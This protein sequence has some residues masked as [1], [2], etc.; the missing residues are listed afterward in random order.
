MR[1]IATLFL[2]LILA[3]GITA[4]IKLLPKKENLKDFTAKTTKI[5]LA[6]DNSFLDLLLK[7][8]VSK[9]WYLSPFEYCTFE[10][11]NKIKTDSSFYF[12]VRVNGQHS[13]ESEPAMEFLSLL[14]GG[15]EAEKGL[16]AM[17]EILSLPLQ[18]INDDSGKI[19]AFLPAYVKIVQAHVLKVIRNDLSAYVGMSTYTDGIDGATDRTILFNENDFAF[20]LDNNDFEAKFKGKGRVVSEKATEEAISNGK[21][22][23]LVT[24]V[25]APVINQRGSYCYK[26]IISTDSNELFFF[27]KH[28]ITNK[29]G[30]GFL[31]EDYRR[32]AVPF[33]KQ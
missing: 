28:K 11:F 25:V 2:T 33:S 29:N 14:K 9:N 23:T 15:P 30:K 5:V 17:P 26:M 13:K 8:A 31:S 21:A 10:E 19:F 16:N 20:K 32:I 24:L 27:R 18:P 3:T 1:K 7:D 12:L 6:G 22:N 4:Q